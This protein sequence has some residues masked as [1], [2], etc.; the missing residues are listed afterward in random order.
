MSVEVG[1]L[2]QWVRR[3]ARL[4]EVL[5]AEYTQW[6][7]WIPVALGAGIG[8]Y[9]TLPHPMLWLT[10]IFLSA[11]LVCLLY[12]FREAWSQFIAWGGILFALGAGLA[13]GRAEAVRAPVLQRPLYKAS[14]VGYVEAREQRPEGQV[15]LIIAPL[16]LAQL[17]KSALPKRLRLTSRAQLSPTIEIGAKIRAKVDLRPPSGPPLPG[18]YDFSRYAWFEQL[19][20]TGVIRGPI[21]LLSA[22]P[23]ASSIAEALSRGRDALT[24]HIQKTLPGTAGVLMAALVTGDR[25]A[26]PEQ[27]TDDMRNS[28]LAHLLSISGLHIALVTGG[29]F[30]LVRRLLC[31]LPALALRLPVKA[32]AAIAAA[33]SAIGYTLLSGASVPTVRSCLATL[34]VLAGVFLGRQAIS[35]RLVAWGATLILFVRPEALLNPSFQ[36]SFAA[37]TGLI[38]LYQSQLGRW[39]LPGHETPFPGRL[40]R[41]G[42][43]MLASGLVA[44]VMLAPIALFHFNQVGLYGLVAN[45]IAIPLT[46]FWIMPAIAFALLMD[47]L[48]LGT[49]GYSLAGWGLDLLADTAR[50][51]AS[52]PGSVAHWRLIPPGAFAVIMLGL[53]WLALWRTPLRWWGGLPLI[54]GLALS[55][56]API[57]D[58]L[59]ARD[60]RVLAVRLQDGQLAFSSL[61]R[62]R[63]TRSSWL[64]DMGLVEGA[65][66]ADVNPELGV[67]SQCRNENICRFLIT[68]EGRLWRLLLITTPA[69]NRQIVMACKA[70]DIV[71]SSRY[72][73]GACQPGLI[74]LGRKQ[75]FETGAVALYF[76]STS[77]YFPLTSRHSVQ[78]ITAS[79][80]Q[81]DHPWHMKVITKP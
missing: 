43:G 42:I 75:L 10:A 18:G 72:L 69:N 38:A 73:P 41:H 46:S 58:L 81:G 16:A 6:P 2:K 28:G 24:T 3:L 40:A 47:A 12:P 29:V 54:L 39:L 66:I 14:L 27:T 32:I 45:L 26:V 78:I 65:H 20:A 61:R 53:L 33:I 21:T 63:F 55:V 31:L 13:W 68:T 30:I 64:E 44:E 22:A 74:K 8:A 4:N 60:G 25:A 48:A 9:F 19:G 62:G 77:G 15:R 1:S 7:L 80:L 50:F 57:P 17:P 5:L 35:M 23:P 52:W 59:I 67:Q 79:K 49:Y 76:P 11:G 34:T 36:L 71:V 70:S 51:V 56:I 37:V